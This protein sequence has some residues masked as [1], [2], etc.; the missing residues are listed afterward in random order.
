[1]LSE[2]NVAE[3]TELV[4]SQEAVRN[5]RS[6][7]AHICGLHRRRHLLFCGRRHWPSLQRVPCC[8]Y[9]RAYAVRGWALRAKMLE[10]GDPIVIQPDLYQLAVGGTTSKEQLYD[11]AEILHVVLHMVTKVPCLTVSTSQ[12]FLTDQLALEAPSSGPIAQA[13]SHSNPYSPSPGHR[14]HDV[15]CHGQKHNS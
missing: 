3:S 4:G 12:S 10:S 15:F 9:L 8:V 13:L 5:P 7:L 6:L 11:S 1:M 14:Q 2:Y